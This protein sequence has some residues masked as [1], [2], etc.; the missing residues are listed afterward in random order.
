MNS[1][2]AELKIQLSTLL[3]NVLYIYQIVY[4]KVLELVQP[5]ECVPNFPYHRGDLVRHYCRLPR[6]NNKTEI[7]LHCL[8]YALFIYLFKEVK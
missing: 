2:I 4:P 3:S 1:Y 6:H 7:Q 5:N 8:I